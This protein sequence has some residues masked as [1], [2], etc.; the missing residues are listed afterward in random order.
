MSNSI[1]SRSDSYDVS[2]YQQYAHDDMTTL[3]YNGNHYFISTQIIYQVDSDT[4]VCHARLEFIVNFISNTSRRMYTEKYTA[5]TKQNAE[6][7]IES[8]AETCENEMR[9]IEDN[10][11]VDVDIDF[12]HQVE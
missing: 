2:D 8:M 7:R 6:S 5:E 1:D 3:E 11:T 4:Y 12:E 9:R 10:S